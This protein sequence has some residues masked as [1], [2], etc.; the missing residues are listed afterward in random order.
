MSYVANV[1]LSF[2]ICEDEGP[3]MAEVNSFF[4]REGQ[5]RLNGFNRYPDPDCCLGGSKRLERPSFVAAFN[6]LPTK[7]FIEHV[8]NAV[9]W[10]FPEQVQLF[11]CGQDDE[12]YSIAVGKCD[13]Y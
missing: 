1:I 13:E 7:Q 9:H 11:I 10:E 5:E 2:S 3:R 12:R 4:V 8:R 6:Y